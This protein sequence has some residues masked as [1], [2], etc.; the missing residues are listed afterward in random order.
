MLDLYLKLKRTSRYSQSMFIDKQCY[1]IG[2]QVRYECCRITHCCY[3]DT[4]TPF[5]RAKEGSTG[6][7]RKPL[8]PNTQQAST[9]TKLYG[10]TSNRGF[11]IVFLCSPRSTL[12]RA[13]SH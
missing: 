2:I 5:T 13:T 6:H 1:G 9:N 4:H 8:I 7:L 12:I 3:K 11:V 10:W